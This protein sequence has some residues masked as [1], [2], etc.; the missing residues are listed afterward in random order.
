MAG[1]RKHKV[2]GIA[3]WQAVAVPPCMPE[4]ED[5]WATVRF[6]RAHYAREKIL[7]DAEVATKLCQWPR[8]RYDG[9]L[10]AR[11]SLKGADLTD[12]NLTQEQFDS[13][14]TDK[15]TMVPPH[16]KRPGKPPGEDA[17]G[18]AGEAR[19]PA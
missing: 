2:L 14:I 18:E 13:A 4:G 6:F 12:T 1:L 17:P 15:D 16:I 11:A 8:G 19:A 7:A 9:E 10:P 3:E 5:L